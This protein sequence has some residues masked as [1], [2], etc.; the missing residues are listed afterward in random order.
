MPIRDELV[1]AQVPIR[2]HHFDEGRVS[3]MARSDP[4]RLYD[5]ASPAVMDT[6]FRWMRA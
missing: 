4:V 3:H 5:S 1:T 2:R 6:H